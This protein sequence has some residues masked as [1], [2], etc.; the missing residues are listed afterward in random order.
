MLARK[1]TDIG[2]GVFILLGIAGLFFLAFKASNL[3]NTALG[4]TYQI[5]ANFEN[6]GTLKRRAP[7]KISG[8]VIGRVSDIFF[9][10]ENLNAKVLLDIATEY[11]L[12]EDSTALIMTSGLLGEQFISLE[13]GIEEARIPPGG[14][15][16]QVQSAISL[17]KLISKFMFESSAK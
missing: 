2:V 6:I 3:G 16:Y 9:D 7:V 17:E 5:S 10:Q 15:I 12:P 4:N 11:Q 13:Y 1:V 8:V 14:H